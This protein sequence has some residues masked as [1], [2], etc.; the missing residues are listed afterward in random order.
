VSMIGVTSGIGNGWGLGLKNW[1][2]GNLFALCFDYC[3]KYIRSTALFHATTEAFLFVKPSILAGIIQA[4]YVQLEVAR[5]MSI[6]RGDNS[7]VFVIPPEK[8]VVR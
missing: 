8:A 7:A 1:A 5:Q 2:I 3:C 4:C 6:H